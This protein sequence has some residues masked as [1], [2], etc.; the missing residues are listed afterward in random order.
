[1]SFTRRGFLSKLKKRTKCCGFKNIV[2]ELN[3]W[4][5][6]IPLTRIVQQEVN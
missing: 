4:N 3:E 6:R 1:M 2:P 5:D